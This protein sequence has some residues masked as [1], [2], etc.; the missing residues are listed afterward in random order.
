MHTYLKIL[1]LYMTL[2]REV[3]QAL[4]NTQFIRLECE[5]FVLVWYIRVKTHQK[6]NLAEARFFIDGA[7]RDRTDDLYAASVALSQLS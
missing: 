5:P 7:Y 1:Q 2:R 3:S 6:K 4:P